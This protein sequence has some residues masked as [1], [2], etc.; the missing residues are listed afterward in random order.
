MIECTEWSKITEI[1]K[2]VTKST[3]EFKIWQNESSKLTKSMKKA[4]T[5]HQRST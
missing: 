2:G 3:Y 1:S 5:H 4:G